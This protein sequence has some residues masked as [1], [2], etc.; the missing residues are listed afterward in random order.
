MYKILYLKKLIYILSL[1]SISLNAQVNILTPNFKVL[2][3]SNQYVYANK[4]E[5]K[6]I[7]ELI[8]NESV[9][10]FSAKHLINS[11][12]FNP[13]TWLKIEVVNNSNLT[14]F[15]FEVN[16]TYID[17]LALFVAKK[18]SLIKEFPKK[19]LYF[20]QNN[21]PS[22]FKNKYAYTYT[23]NIPKKDTISIF[24]NGIVNDGSFKVL[25]KIWSLEHYEKRKKEVQY[26]TSYLIFFGGFVFL[27][28]VLSF[29][30]FAFSK[31]ALYLYY[32]GFVSIMYLN[33]LI[34]RHFFSP[35]YVEK[36]LFYDNNFSEM[37]GLLQLFLM[38]QYFRH[39]FR[40]K[41]NHNKL[42]KFLRYLAIFALSYF[43]IALFMRKLHWFYAFSFYFTKLFMI[44]STILVFSIAIYLALKKQRIAFYFIIAYTPLFFLIMHFILTAFGLTNGY[45]PLEWEFVIFFEVFVLTIAMAHNYYIQTQ[46]NLKNVERIYTQRNKISRDLHDNIGS[47]LTFIK[48]S[49]DNLKY[50]TKTTDEKLISKLDQISSFSSHTINQLRDTVWAMSKENISIDNL[51]NRVQGLIEKTKV[52]DSEL[53]FSLICNASKEIIFDSNKGINIFRVI[54]EAVNNTI[55][56]AEAS[57]IEIKLEESTKQ[58]EITISD[59]GKGFDINNIELGNG[60]SNME[61]RMAEI[62]SQIHIHSIKNKG[63][64]I[65][66]NIPK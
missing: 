61:K 9:F 65:K 66:M 20:K 1:I 44:F 18:K 46:E 16:Q 10:K 63:T 62:N 17:S 36:Y 13:Y 2:T 39:F 45:N 25:N 12:P 30:M 55:K 24:V 37:I 3:I 64:S 4:T 19:G 28:L 57:N 27:V 15:I 48:S 38:F 34:L 47:Q 32:A 40:L 29:F 42:D 58:I 35:L 33:I 26:K 49:I 11:G 6:K 53:Q 51:C 5:N 52:I 59:N 41:G 14:D 56:Y 50:I 43:L 21:K 8:N 7:T 54:Q 31:K 60:L 22:F 23:I